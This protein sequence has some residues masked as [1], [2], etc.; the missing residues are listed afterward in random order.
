LWTVSAQDVCTNIYGHHVDKTATVFSSEA[1]ALM[2]TINKDDPGDESHGSVECKD[3]L[4][5]LTSDNEHVER[6]ESGSEDKS[7]LNLHQ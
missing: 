5:L 4:V 7:L 1:I 3:P 2:T 6:E